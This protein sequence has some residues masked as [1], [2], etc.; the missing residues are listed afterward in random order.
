[1]LKV[2][3]LSKNSVFIITSATSIAFFLNIPIKVIVVLY[4]YIKLK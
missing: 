4:N 2:L 3:S 1:M